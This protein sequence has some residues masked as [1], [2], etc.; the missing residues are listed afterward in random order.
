MRGQFQR[1]SGFADARFSGKQDQ[2][3]A[4]R[5]GPVERGA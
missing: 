1:G 4:A 2:T 5:A 3:P